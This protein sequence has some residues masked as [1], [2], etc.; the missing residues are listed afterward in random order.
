MRSANVYHT[1]EVQVT[2]SVV[3][4]GDGAGVG[5]EDVYVVVIQGHH[6]VVPLI[7]VERL[8]RVALHE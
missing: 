2:G 8:L 7:V 3:V 1:F 4:L 5:L 6:H